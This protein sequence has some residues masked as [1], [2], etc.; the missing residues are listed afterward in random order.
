MLET[1][2]LRLRRWMPCHEAPFAAMNADPAVMEYFP[3]TITA[4]QSATAIA[5]FEANFETHG[6]SFWAVEMRHNGEF[7]GSVGLELYALA[8]DNSE[9]STLH[10]AIGWQLAQAYWRQGLA[11]EA[12]QAVQAYAKNQLKINEIIAVMAEKN[13][14]SISVC[15]RLGMLRDANQQHTDANFPAGHPLA[16]QALYRLRLR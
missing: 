1:N 8:S 7:V 5:I 13:Q 3:A 14:R 16:P 12:A 2:R 11:F 6:Y 4:Q 9:A 15:E 10:V